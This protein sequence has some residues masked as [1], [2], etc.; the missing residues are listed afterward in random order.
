MAGK[1]VKPPTAIGKLLLAA[2]LRA[3]VTWVELERELA[4]RRTTREFWLNGRVGR[5]PLVPVALLAAQLEIDGNELLIAVVLQ[6]IPA[7]A[8]AEL[9][10]YF[11]GGS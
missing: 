1:R 11:K 2:K 6:E 8:E 9:D 4:I 3:G 10:R 5:L 7:W